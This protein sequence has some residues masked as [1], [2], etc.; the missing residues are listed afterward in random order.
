M[1]TGLEYS[2]NHRKSQ[3]VSLHYVHHCI[4]QWQLQHFLTV[5]HI[6][7][8]PFTQATLEAF[9][10]DLVFLLVKVLSKYVQV[11]I[12]LSARLQ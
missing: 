7:N 11:I 9:P 2:D 4:F 8:L 3:V 6:G 5:E 12:D 10:E 1:L